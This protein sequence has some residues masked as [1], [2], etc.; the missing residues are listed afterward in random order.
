MT[1][2]PDTTLLEQF[3]K[4]GSEEAF[5]E[6]V[7]RHIGLVHSVAARGTNNSQHAQEI[8]QAVFIILARKA[9]SLSRKTVLSGWLYHTARLTAANFKRAEFRRIRREQ[10]VFMQAASNDTDIESAWREMGPSLEDAMAQLGSKDRDAIVLRFFEN[11]SLREV[12]MAMGLEE[13]AA[14]KRVA[15]GLGKLRAFFTKRG[16]TFSAAI[17][18]TAVAANSV[19]AAP[20]G[21]VTTIAAA[22]AKGTAVTASTLTLVKG[23][24]K[25]M[26]WTKAKTAIV[27]GIGLLLVAGTTITAVKKIN[28]HSYNPK[29]FWE[30][31]WPTGLPPGEVI[32]GVN[33]PADDPTASSFPASPKR[34]C[35]VSGLL[36]QCM[37]VTGF[38]YLIDKDVSAGSVQFGNAETLNGSQWVAVFENALQTG[39]PEWWDSATKARRR[40]NLVLIKF[41]E[42]KVVLVV[43]RDKAAKYQ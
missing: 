35:S 42:K 7:R 43:P 11:K 31:Q 17:I 37:Q 25:L 41:P 2:A 34:A 20:A 8:T 27:A 12:G 4:S 5:A 16:V 1:D 22:T 39:Q 14:Q 29:D 23:A 24:L 6:L 13:R 19:Q 26:A 9:A 15:R 10:E 40:E 21:L 18:A 33:A 3:A 32:P 30:T 28:S 36:N 38:H